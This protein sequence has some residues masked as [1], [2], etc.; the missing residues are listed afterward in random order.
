MK[1]FLI[2]LSIF[3]LIIIHSKELIDLIGYIK[4]YK[5]KK[6]ETLIDI[7]RINNLAFPEIMSANQGIR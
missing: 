6:D 5:T 1:I 4:Y 3:K 7:A 2:I